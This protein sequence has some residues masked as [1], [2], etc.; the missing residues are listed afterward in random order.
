M[1]RRGLPLILLGLVAG[2]GFAACGRDSTAEG[3][4]P[5][6]VDNVGELPGPFQVAIP[7]TVATVPS[8]TPVSSVEATQPSRPDDTAATS[9][10]PSSTR[11]SRTT[12]AR[13]RFV[14][15]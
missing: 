2:P 3:S 12:T 8:S 10:E 11:S 4:P 6:T 5:N 1:R 13:D 15:G 9:D 14:A 7:P